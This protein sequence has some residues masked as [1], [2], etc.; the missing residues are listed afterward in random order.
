MFPHNY[1]NVIYGARHHQIS[2]KAH[3]NTVARRE[4][5][6]TNHVHQHLTIR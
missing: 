2:G 6:P 4:D 1:L 3:F 5:L